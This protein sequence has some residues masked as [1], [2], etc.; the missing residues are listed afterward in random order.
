MPA[1]LLS[2]A[3]RRY[4]YVKD[5]PDARDFTTVKLGLTPSAARAVD[6]LALMG[7]VLDQG[8]QGSCT[9]HTDCA[10]RE[11]LHYKELVRQGK[12]LVINRDG[13]GL[14]SPS[15][16]Y[17]VCRELDGSLA[18]GDCGSTGRT[19]CQA[20]VKYGHALRSEVPYKDT[21]FTTAPTA[22]QRVKAFA[23]VS[24]GYHRLTTLDDMRSV[25][26]SGYNFKVGF[27][28]FESFE[29]PWSVPGYMPLP[30]AGEGQLGG[31]EVLVVG[32]DDDK[33]ALLIRNSWGKGWGLD[34]NFWFPYAAVLRPDV[35]MDA[36]VQHL[37]TWSK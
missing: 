21:D 15:F 7:P 19:T 18:E 9:A 8:A 6:N 16:T 20:A 28:V 32:Y 4:G 37:G 24:G 22:E 34:G 30:E 12:S 11:F 25:L 31:H 35:F 33:S 17:Y 1:L 10:D 26:A 14:Y 2:P 23:W 27:A 3:G 29:S 5:A 13:E 36:W